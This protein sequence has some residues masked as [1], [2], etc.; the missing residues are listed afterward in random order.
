MKLPKRYFEDRKE[1]AQIKHAI[2]V[3]VPEGV[4][5]SNLVIAL[6]EVLREYVHDCFRE[7]DEE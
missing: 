1:Q 7:E 3:A 2:V 5:Y 6:A 4:A